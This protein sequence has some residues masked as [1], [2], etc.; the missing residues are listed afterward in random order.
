MEN[1]DVYEYKCYLCPEKFQDVLIATNHLKAVHNK[2]DKDTLQC[3]R[4]QENTIFCSSS[5]Q[6]IKALR[7][8]LR[9]NKCKYFLVT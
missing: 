3:M 6:S 5:F 2:I 9:E 1:V 4:L 8:H 7:K